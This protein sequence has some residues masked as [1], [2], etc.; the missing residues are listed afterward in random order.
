MSLILHIETAT[1]VCSAALSKDG[2]LLDLQETNDPRSHATRLSPFIK[3]LMDSNNYDFSDLDAVSISLGPGSYT[4]LRIGVSTAK[5]IGYGAGIPLIGISTLQALANRII[6]EGK[7]VLGDIST[8]NLLLCPMLDARRME[9]YTAFF[10][11]QLEL[12]R[13][14]QA[15]IIEPDSYMEYL[16]AGPVLFFGNGSDKCRDIIQHPNAEFIPDIE[17]SSQYMIQLAE[18]AW[19]KQEFVDTAYFEP[20]YLKEFI[21]TIPKNKIIPPQKPV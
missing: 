9:V 21:A 10:S 12:A 14:V 4:G 13:K 16:E 18:A 8:K 11:P 15:D 20:F 17:P 19:E 6:Q 1:P 5:G 7:V 2:Q 3:E